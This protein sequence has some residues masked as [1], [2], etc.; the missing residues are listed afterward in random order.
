MWTL[1]RSIVM[2]TYLFYTNSEFERFY[3]F[4][5]VIGI[6]TYNTPKCRVNNI[7]LI[8]VNIDIFIDLVLYTVYFSIARV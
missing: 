6:Y 4:G 5:V 2:L 7:I 3:S 1:P 8:Y